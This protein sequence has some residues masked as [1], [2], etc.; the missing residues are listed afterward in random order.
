MKNHAHPSVNNEHARLSLD[1]V[2]LQKYILTRENASLILDWHF[3]EYY[4]TM[5]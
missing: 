4:E 1:P 2:V 5:D 3:K